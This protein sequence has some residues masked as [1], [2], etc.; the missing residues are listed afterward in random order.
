[1][2]LAAAP[3]NANALICRVQVH[4]LEASAGS[5]GSPMKARYSSIEVMGQ[6]GVAGLL[7]LR[8]CSGHARRRQLLTVC[9]R[10]IGRRRLLQ[11]G[12]RGTL[13]RCV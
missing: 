4:R 7:Q 3:E 5:G 1:M 13:R 9:R 10:H 12:R 6:A 8:G 11:A 2:L